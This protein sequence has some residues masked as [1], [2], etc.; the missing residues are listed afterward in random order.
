MFDCQ[1]LWQRISCLLRACLGQQA[2][3]ALGVVRPRDTVPRDKARLHLLCNFNPSCFI[4]CSTQTISC[5]PASYFQPAAL[6]ADTTAAQLLRDRTS[7]RHDSL[8]GTKLPAEKSWMQHA[9]HAGTGSPPKVRL[10]LL[11]LHQSG[12]R[13]A[14]RSANESARVR[15][16]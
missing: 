1:L 2:G 11:S 15:F 10:P 3:A 4:H 13:F 14:G 9:G 8:P 16:A 5:A 12:W 6:S 7:C